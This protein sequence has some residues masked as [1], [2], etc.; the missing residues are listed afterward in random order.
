M[1][2]SVDPQAE[3]VITIPEPFDAE[4]AAQFRM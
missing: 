4:L 2:E 3:L 1:G